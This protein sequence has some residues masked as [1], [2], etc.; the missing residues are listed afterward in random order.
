MSRRVPLHCCMYQRH[1]PAWGGTAAK[2]PA[3]APPP[4]PP[5]RPPAQGWVL[6][7]ADSNGSSSTSAFTLPGVVLA[8][9]NYTLVTAGGR[10]GPGRHNSG[11]G[12]GGAPGAGVP[13][14]RLRRLRGSCLRDPACASAAPT[15]IGAQ[16]LTA[17]ALVRVGAEG[18]GQLRVGW[19]AP[20]VGGGGGASPT[21]SNPQNGP[22]RRELTW[23]GSPQACPCP[24]PAALAAEGQGPAQRSPQGCSSASCSHACPAA[25]RTSSPPSLRP[26]AAAAT[27]LLSRGTPAAPPPPPGTTAPAACRARRPRWPPGGALLPGQ[28]VADAD[29]SGRRAGQPHGRPAQ[30]V[31]ATACCAGA[32]AAAASR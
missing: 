15:C 23:F 4:S 12:G 27:H 16:G 21:R 3:H 9:G 20:P 25:T 28:Q 6:S 13:P 22:C 11:T 26:P 5:A 7:E 32:L 29:P 1:A 18:E 17:M 30:A 10:R 2:M 14:G 8:P 31:G 24:S 19:S